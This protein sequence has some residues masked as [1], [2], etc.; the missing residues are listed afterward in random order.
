[1]T[2]AA[3]ATASGVAD[4]LPIGIV[5]TDASGSAEFANQAWGELSSQPGEAWR[6]DGWLRVVGAKRRPKLLQEIL[7]DCEKGLTYVR[8]WVVPRRGSGARV[9]HVLARP[10][11]AEQ[12]LTR[13]AIAVVDVSA[14]RAHLSDLTFRATHDELT[15]LYNRAQFD[16]FVQHAL[17]RRL[18]EPAHTAAV[19]FLDVDDLKATNDA[20][21]HGAGDELLKTVATRL[22]GAVRPGDV[23]ARYGGD[24]FAVLCETLRNDVEGVVIADRIRTAVMAPYDGDGWCSASVGI[25]AA[26]GHLR[27]AELVRDADHAMYQSKHVRSPAPEAAASSQIAMA[28]QELRGPLNE[29]VSAVALLSERS[30]RP[31]AGAID[32][33]IG[34][35]DR[36]SSRVAAIVDGLL[37]MARPTHP[38]P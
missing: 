4:L 8:E 25:A 17:D 37:D 12:R 34:V 32:A 23:V 7:A 18:R 22:K 38:T 21:G 14:Q 35:I 20:F 28:A 33:A 2:G 29:L 5:V 3:D 13:I 1:M 19:V 10:H 26:D 6:G 30:D 9:F 24:E 11:L 27:V 36:Q 31:Q 15:G 16:M